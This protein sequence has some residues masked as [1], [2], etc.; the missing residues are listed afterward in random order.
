[1]R[2]GD[3]GTPCLRTFVNKKIKARSVKRGKENKS[4]YFRQ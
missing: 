2:E 1:M 3:N 4:K